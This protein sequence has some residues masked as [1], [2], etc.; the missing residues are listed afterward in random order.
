ML[1][2]LE[3]KRLGEAFEL[4]EA[5][6]ARVLSDLLATKEKIRL[7]DPVQ[8]RLY[9]D[10]RDIRGRLRERPAEESAS[11]SEV[12]QLESTREHLLEE[13]RQ[14]CPQLLSLTT[15]A[16]VSL[17]EVQKAA[18]EGGYDVLAYASLKD[19]LVIWHIGPTGVH[20]RS[21]NLYRDY[22]AEK[23]TALRATLVD[24]RVAF[25]EKT[26]RQ[27]HLLLVQP[28][29]QFIS[30]EHIVVIPHQALYF[31]PFQA[32]CDYPDGHFLAEKF[33]F[34]YA[35]TTR[36]LLNK[37]PVKPLADASI[38]ALVGPDLAEGAAETDDIVRLYPKGSQ[39]VPLSDS[40]PT[41]LAR[42][43]GGYDIIHIA[44][45]GKFDPLS[46]MQSCVFLTG[47]DGQPSRLTAADMFGLSLDRTRLVTLSAC[48]TGLV[49]G[50]E[51]GE[52]LGIPRALLY[53]GA[54]A[55]YL[56]RW[57]VDSPTTLALMQT[58]YREA[59]SAPLDVAARRAALR[60]KADPRTSHPFYWA[61]FD[62]IGR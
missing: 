56:S 25:D 3:Q 40:T 21:V 54:D 45:H 30:T 17:T 5:S 42:V 11:S 36:S 1:I 34:S 26:S 46:P 55:V 16:P 51:A 6:R 62:L 9:E 10:L 41:Y 60:I 15:A 4:F 39:A 48:E 22:L 49:E 59:R 37:P 14:K 35:P 50:I 13:I 8:R 28:M 43:C 20:V 57:K 24:P 29:L 47:S 18:T 61:A 33:A 7:A 52:V 19:Q 32:L 12:R 44:A 58:F 53:A 23:V 38:L 31:L 2:L 27:L